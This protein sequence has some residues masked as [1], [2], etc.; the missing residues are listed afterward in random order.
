MIMIAD[1]FT[2]YFMKHFLE[3]SHVGIINRLKHQ[4]TMT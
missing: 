3:D 2:E 1:D 4:H